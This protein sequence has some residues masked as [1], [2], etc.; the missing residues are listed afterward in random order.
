MIKQT[1]PVIRDAADPQIV[2]QS[3]LRGEPNGRRRRLIKGGLSAGP[4]ILTLASRPS[5]AWHCRSPSG[6][7][8]GNGSKGHEALAYGGSARSPAQWVADAVWCNDTSATGGKQLFH[9][10]FPTSPI[11]FGAATTFK[12]VMSKWS[13]GTA[14]EQFG[15]FVLAAYLNIQKGWV[16]GLCLTAAEVLKMWANGPLGTY[17]AAVGAALWNK[18]DIIAYLK[19]TWIVGSWGTSNSDPKL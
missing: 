3:S 19:E 13:T 10:T 11:N 15:A 6:F 7:V 8:S 16:P 2:E 9:P 18:D 17:Q 12:T 1:E 5:Y 14:N 4:V